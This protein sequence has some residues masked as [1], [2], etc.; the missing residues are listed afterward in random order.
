MS[1]PK[2]S[3]PSQHCPVQS[4]FRN[5]PG[6]CRVSAQSAWLV[7]GRAR[8]TQAV[9]RQVR[10]HPFIGWAAPCIP[11][12]LIIE[13]SP[14]H[15]YAPTSQSAPG[16][17]FNTHQVLTQV[18][19]RPHPAGTLD[20]AFRGRRD[21]SAG[22]GLRNAE[23]GVMRPLRG[24]KVRSCGRLTEVQKYLDASCWRCWVLR[25]FLCCRHS[26]IGY[27]SGQSLSLIHI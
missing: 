8:I 23:C 14:H 18:D 17:S 24:L 22:C 27:L 6:E 10:R 15:S 2:P 4:T 12:R 7:P 16:T 9:T 1:T 26:P 20:R 21:G 13:L 25:V 3:S 11:N 19:A 5:L